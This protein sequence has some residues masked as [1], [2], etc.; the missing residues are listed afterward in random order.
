MEPTEVVLEAGE[1]VTPLD[2]ER[3]LS[4]KLNHADRCDTCGAQAFVWAIIPNSEHGLM[5][6]G[7]HFN[8]YEDNLR[9]V[10]I[11]IWDERYKINVK[12]SASSPD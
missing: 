11:D 8:K 3:P 9:K 12:A 10:A 1:A 4:N 5:F 2:E 6:C 7:H